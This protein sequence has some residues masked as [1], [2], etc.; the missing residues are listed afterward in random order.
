MKFHRRWYY[1]HVSG[2]TIPLLISSPQKRFQKSK[3][4]PFFLSPYEKINKYC[5]NRWW[6]QQKKK[7]L[8]NGNK[9]K[10]RCII[11]NKIARISN[12]LV[13]FLF[14]AI[15]YCDNIYLFFHTEIKKWWNLRFLKSF[16]GELIKSGVVEPDTSK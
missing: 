15:T 16:C 10:E 12:N 11:Y 6:L 14:A 2:S 13:F 9:W 8:Q 1:F 3:I 7:N 5:H 4:P